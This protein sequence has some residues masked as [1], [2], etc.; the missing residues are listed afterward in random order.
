MIWKQEN[1][2]ERRTNGCYFMGKGTDS[3]Q[4]NPPLAIL[5]LLL[6]IRVNL[7]RIFLVIFKSYNKQTL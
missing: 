3:S 4:L 7:Q 2:E 5:L 6:I 1:R